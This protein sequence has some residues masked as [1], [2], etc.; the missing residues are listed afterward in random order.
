[1]QRWQLQ[2]AKAKLSALVQQASREG[3]QVITVRGRQEVIV[4]SAETYHKKIARKEPSFLA[5][6]NRSPMKGIT[7]KITRD[8]SAVRPVE[9]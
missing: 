9:L 5:F 7:L 3:P 1:M 4:L 6:I 8:R 2:E